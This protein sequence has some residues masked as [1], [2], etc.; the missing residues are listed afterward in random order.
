[1]P[2]AR[3]L[4]NFHDAVKKGSVHSLQRPPPKPLALAFSFRCQGF[5]VRGP[6][7]NREP[8]A[9]ASFI[10]RIITGRPLAWCRS[11]TR[12]G[13]NPAASCFSRRGSDSDGSAV[14][15]FAV[16]YGRSAGDRDARKRQFRRPLF[17]TRRYVAQRSI[18][19]LINK[20]LSRVGSGL[21]SCWARNP[22]AQ[23]PPRWP[24]RFILRGGAFV[25][26]GAR[27]CRGCAAHD[28]T[29]GIFLR[30]AFATYR[31]RFLAG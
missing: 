7:D 13:S 20:A 24:R 11:P 9:C 17:R 23:G 10:A 3:F 1:V 6:A 19:A 16:G 15:S 22:R 26:G 21:G 12:P 28:C 8:V 30:E 14:D 25:S 4:R 29:N 2:I 31:W 18:T 5:F 27:S